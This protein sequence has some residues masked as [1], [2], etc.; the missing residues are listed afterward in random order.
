[1]TLVC[2]IA[3]I[4]ACTPPAVSGTLLVQTENATPQQVAHTAQILTARF[5]EILPAMASTVSA[6]T[7]DTTI[8][9]TFR[10]GAPNEDVLRPLPLT[11]GE[12]RIAPADR[13]DES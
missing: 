2:S 6:T 5:D 11:R 9:F 1:M 13:A 3:W 8:T 10:G 7:T 12:L 4:T